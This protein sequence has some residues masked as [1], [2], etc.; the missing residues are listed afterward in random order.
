MPTFKVQPKPGDI[1]GY[2]G[3]YW[4]SSFINLVTYGIPYVSISHVGI[5]GEYKGELY[6][7]ESLHE[8]ERPCAITGDLF[9]GTQATRFDDIDHYRGK[10]WH[11]PLYRDL[12]KH[13]LR[14]QKKFLLDTLQTPYDQIGAF[15]SGGIGFSFVESLLRREDLSSL[16]CSEW[17]AASHAT[18]GILPTANS[19]KWSPN[20]FVRTERRLGILRK[21]YQVICDSSS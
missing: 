9:S 20:R 18:T 17:N 8:P 19:S 21:P 14:R 1:L 11:Y 6:V 13:E 16:F 4:T 5:I 3:E 15:R 2:S 10:V 12:Y 7:F